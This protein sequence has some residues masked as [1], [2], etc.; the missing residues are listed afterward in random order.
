MGL[1]KVEKTAIL[2]IVV[3]LGLVV[4]KYTL[5]RIS[6]SIALVADTWHSI[7]DVFVSVLVLFG[8]WIN[9]KK[10]RFAAILENIIALFI[11]VLIFSA[12]YF[13]AVKSITG[14]GYGEIRYLPIVLVGT[15]ISAAISRLIGKYEIQVGTE[16]DSPSMIADGYHSIMDVYTTVVVTIGLLGHM[17]GLKLD[18][19]AAIIVILFVIEV[20][21]EISVMSIK[22]L[23]KN[24]AFSIG[25]ENK[26]ANKVLTKI[27][28]PVRELVKMITGR[29]LNISASAIIFWLQHRK[30]TIV[31]VVVVV[32]AVIYI[33]SGIF[34]VR[35]HQGVVVSLFG[36][37]SEKIYGPGL[38]YVLPRPFGKVYKLDTKL[39]R[40]LESGFRSIENKQ[41][42]QSSISRSSYEWHS[43]HISGIYKKEIGESIML[44]GDENLIDLNVVVKYKISNPHD[45]LF[46]FNDQEKL[47]RCFV[48]DVLRSIVSKTPID[49]ILTESRKEIEKRAQEKLQTE[50]DGIR[51]GITI[52]SIALQD[53]HPPVEVVNAFRE[54]SSAKEEKALTINEAMADKNE[55]IPQARAQATALELEAEAYRASKVEN[56]AGEGGRF[57]ALASEYR[58]SKDVTSF[59]LYIQSMEKVLSGRRKFIVSPNLEP[60]ALDLRIFA[61]GRSSSTKTKKKK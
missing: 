28:K 5:A 42:E 51:A 9:R 57:L 58:K 40:R 36:K 20:G 38:H 14:I 60:G 11:A 32:A 19:I 1:G 39:V 52:S 55:K 22:G 44:T 7:S 4:L 24:T 56:A 3:C 53:V 49:D 45:F 8:A 30:K 41:I 23:I 29:D 46:R 59:R 27:G 17:I 34:V 37:A 25:R 33:V 2:A 21:I 26:A 54:V 48:E 35:P 18:T 10:W 12:A 31:L 43:L 16:K 13:L 6:G 50:V 15:V 61:R 47:V